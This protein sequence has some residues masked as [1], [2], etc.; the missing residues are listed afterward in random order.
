MLLNAKS[1]RNTRSKQN[2]SQ[3]KQENKGVSDCGKRIDVKQLIRTRM[4]TLLINIRTY[5]YINIFVNRYLYSTTMQSILSS[6]S[7]VTSHNNNTFT[8][9]STTWIKLKYKK[10]CI[11]EVSSYRFIFAWYSHYGCFIVTVINMGRGP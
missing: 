4:T 11:Y 9:T 8:S 3:I 2:N 7:K 6:R 1:N 5:L 10:N